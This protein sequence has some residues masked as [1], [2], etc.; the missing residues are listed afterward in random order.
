ME[1][2]K[3]GVHEGHCCVLHGCKYGDKDC[4]VTN[5]LTKQDYI[6]ESCEYEGFKNLEHI[7]EY[8]MYQEKIKKAKET[9]EKEIKVSV[10]FIDRMLNH[11]PEWY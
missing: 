4:P 11:E 5:K 9:G 2:S 8:L 7:E 10:E 6:C 3:W 1:K